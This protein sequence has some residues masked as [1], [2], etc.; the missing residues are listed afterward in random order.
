MRELSQH[1]TDLV[2][3]STRAGARR[4]EV[5]IEVNAEKD[6]IIVRVADDG[7][8]MSPDELAAAMDPFY[9]TRS[10][11]RVG[12]G[13]PLAM[14]T[15]ER[16][17]GWLRVRSE[18]GYGTGVEMR[19]RHSHIDRPPLGN[20]HATITAALVGHP[21]VDFVCSYSVDGRR[22][23]VDGAAIRRELD[24]LS[25]CNPAVLRWL[26]RYVEEGIAAVSG[27]AARLEEGEDAKVE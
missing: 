12:L 27:D 7:A 8:G 1:I 25:L 11:R 10:C 16:C 14:A 2:E 6:E 3:N 23:E 13:L 19:L 5:S 22:F 20:L 21:E 26:D 17:A 18:P 4:I 24:G 15:A 9:T